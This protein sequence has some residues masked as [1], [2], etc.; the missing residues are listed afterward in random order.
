MDTLYNF[1]CSGKPLNTSV[2]SIA[3]R[4]NANAEEV[5]EELYGNGSDEEPTIDS[6]IGESESSPLKS[7]LP[8]LIKRSA[9]TDTSVPPLGSG[10]RESSSS[11]PSDNKWRFFSDIKVVEQ[12][13]TSFYYLLKT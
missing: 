5:I 10:N 1:I 11:P 13:S 9:S 12:K 8:K 3:I 7:Y 6:T 2:P 4:F